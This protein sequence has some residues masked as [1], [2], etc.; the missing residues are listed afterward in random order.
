VLVRVFVFFCVVC[1]FLRIVMSNILSCHMSLRSDFLVMITAT[2]SASKT[3]FELS[4]HP[5]V[6]RRAHVFL[7]FFVCVICLFAHS[8]LQYVFTICVTLR[9]SYK[10]QYLLTLHKHLS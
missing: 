1:V 3:M 8:V 10:R 4:L 5:V 7:V 9:V 2:I 6:C